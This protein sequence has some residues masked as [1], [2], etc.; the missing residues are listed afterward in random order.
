MRVREAGSAEKYA[1]AQTKTARRPPPLPHLLKGSA[2]APNSS[3]PPRRATHAA[4]G[5]PPRE[6]AHATNVVATLRHNIVRT[7]KIASA[8]SAQSPGN[9]H[10]Q[11]S[12]GTA[13]L[14]L[15]ILSLGHLPRAGRDQTPAS[16]SR[17]ARVPVHPTVALATA[18][19]PLI[20]RGRDVRTPKRMTGWLNECLSGEATEVKPF[21]RKGTLRFLG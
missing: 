13:P 16:G 17:L 11:G 1:H 2:S 19:V 8:H 18:S 7:P 3:L 12:P 20:R 14:A 10:K 4:K 9:R 21:A 5:L 6:C 15:P